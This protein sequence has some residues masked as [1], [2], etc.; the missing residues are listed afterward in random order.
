MPRPVKTTP[1]TLRQSKGGDPLVAITAYDA[2]M[3]HYADQAGVDII[4]VGD[5]VGNTILGHDGTVPVT[6][7]TMVHHAAAVMRAKPAALVAAD[8]PF[9]E[10]HFDFRRVLMSCQRLMQEAGVDAV[11]IEGGRKLAPKIA[12]LVEAGVPVWGHIGLMPQQVKQLGR[13]K[14]YGV[15]DAETAALIAD[16]QA[17]EA[18]GCF[19][20]LLEMVKPAAAKAVTAAVTIPV[21]GIGAGADCDGQ[22]LVITDVLGLTP[23]YVPGFVQ[24]FADA[25]SVFTRGLTDYTAAVRSRNFP[26]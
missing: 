18:A 21:I 6:L 19:A 25:G 17:L 14:K 11:K 5:S 9:G 23:G 1:H 15:T 4:L 26:R 16:A 10:A 3:A 2:M 13:Y 8:V 20:L 22:I 7:D 24:K 12:R